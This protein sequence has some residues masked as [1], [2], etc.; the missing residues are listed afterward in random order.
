M[1]IRSDREYRD[2]WRRFWL[3]D[4]VRV[5]VRAL[6]MY[7]YRKRVWGW[8]WG[9]EEQ[10]ENLKHGQRELDGRSRHTLPSLVLAHLARNLVELGPVAQLLER[11]FLFG[12]L[13]AQNV[14]HV[15]ASRGLELAFAVILGVAAAGRGL[16]F[17]FGRH[18]VRDG[19]V[20]ESMSVW[21]TKCRASKAG[22][23]R[24]GASGASGM[25][26]RDQP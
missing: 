25:R 1:V 23:G 9:K 10:S 12:V 3:L 14:S 2:V 17:V 24:I 19:V 7:T 8:E 6:Y 21:V 11:F 26:K 18:V 15:D 5:Y 4:C 13:L 22:R 20:D 16:S